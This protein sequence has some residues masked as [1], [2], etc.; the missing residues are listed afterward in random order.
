M[1]LLLSIIFVFFL[2]GTKNYLLAQNNWTKIINETGNTHEYSYSIDVDSI[3]NIY[4]TGYR[5]NPSPQIQTIKLNS[6]GIVQWDINT[7][8]SNLSY[9]GYSLVCRNNNSILVSGLGGDSA[10]I[11]NFNNQGVLEK[12][13]SYITNPKD[14]IQV[15]SMSKTTNNK[16]LLCGRVNYND[17]YTALVDSNFSLIWQRVVPAAKDFI[18]FRS[19]VYFKGNYYFCG[20]Y[21]NE[22]GNLPYIAKIDSNGNLLWGNQIFIY[23]SVANFSGA[24][25][26]RILNNNLLM[27]G[28]TK[29]SVQ[30]SFYRTFFLTLDEEGNKLKSRVING[31]RPEIVSDASMYDNKIIYV[32]DLLNS[33]QYPT[34]SIITILDTNFQV[35]KTKSVVVQDFNQLSSVQV[36]GDNFYF[37]GNTNK[38]SGSNQSADVLIIKTDST[39]DIPTVGIT[40]ENTVLNN[41]SLSQNYPNPFNPST[42]I[43]YSLKK[44]SN[45]ELKLVDVSG[46]FVRLIHSGFKP[47]GNYEISFSSEGLSSGV[48]FVS[49]FSD[50]VLA[51]TKKAV[52]LK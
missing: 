8:F 3:G 15:Y 27:C 4:S 38:K 43:S 49:L 22:V 26:L 39:L 9:L 14:G 46:R 41:F 19:S 11:L 30:S 25:R 20:V 17:G 5:E 34:N 1:K 40:N 45:I 21:V 7:S 24:Q 13:Y 51:D 23:N 47:A 48:Y 42:K 44:S 10:Y 36:K 16:Y 18:S 52:I 35:L 33:T 37:S 6:S 31:T 12:K 28:F 50:G 32:A 29:D 2:L